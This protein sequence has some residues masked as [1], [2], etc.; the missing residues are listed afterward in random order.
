MPRPVDLQADDLARHARRLLSTQGLPA[1][2][3]VLLELHRPADAGL[4]GRDVLAQF[5]AVQ[6]VADLEAQGVAGGQADGRD[7]QVR[8]LGQ[9]FLPD[10]PAASALGR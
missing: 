4:Q 5:V 6:A 3:V 9:Q 7:A 10:R 2:E 1:D 8:A